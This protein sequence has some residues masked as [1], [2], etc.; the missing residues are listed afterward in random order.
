MPAGFRNSVGIPTCRRAR[1]ACE[2]L[3]EGL[4]FGRGSGDLVELQDSQLEFAQCMRDNGVEMGDPDLSNF[5]PGGGDDDGPG[6]GPFGGA[7]DF[8]D[9]DV[10]AALEVCQDEVNVNIGRFGRGGSGS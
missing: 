9:P 10:A 6:R 1:Q 4:L 5:G 2:D 7:I 3:L 8:E